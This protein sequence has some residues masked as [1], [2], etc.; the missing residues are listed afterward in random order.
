M[1]EERYSIRPTEC[2][3]AS[4][5]SNSRRTFSYP[6]HRHLRV[7]FLFPVCHTSLLAIIDSIYDLLHVL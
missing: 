2:S 1:G 4:T 7:D 3:T 6:L 5:T